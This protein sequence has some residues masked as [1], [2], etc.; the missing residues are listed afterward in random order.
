MNASIIPN[1]R[2]SRI[3]WTWILF[4]FFLYESQYI[5]AF[6][7]IR[8]NA[9]AVPALLGIGSIF[10]RPR[11]IILEKSLGKEEILNDAGIFFT[12]AFWYVPG[13]NFASRWIFS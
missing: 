8:P 12:Q 3:L 5:H 9:A 4:G 6:G 11:N 10:F 2:F 7:F 13:I 1:T